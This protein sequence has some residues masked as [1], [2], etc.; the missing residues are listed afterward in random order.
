MAVDGVVKGGIGKRW[1]IGAES[2]DF[3]ADGGR[4]W[5][6]LEPSPA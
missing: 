2:N 1:V 4:E 5:T 3:N 6:F